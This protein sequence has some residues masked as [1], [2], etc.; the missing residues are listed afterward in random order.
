MAEISGFGG[1]SGL[2]TGVIGLA[3]VR[4]GRRCGPR[5]AHS[6]GEDEDQPLPQ[7]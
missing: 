3:R 6:A 1:T 2:H 4:V 7:R 5:A